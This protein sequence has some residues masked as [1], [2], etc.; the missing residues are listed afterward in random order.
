M[1]NMVQHGKIFVPESKRAELMKS[2]SSTPAYSGA[3]NNRALRG[4]SVNAREDAYL[5][6]VDTLTERSRDLCRNNSLARGIIE[7]SKVSTIGEGLQPQ[8]RIDAEYL[9]LSEEKTA[10]LQKQIEREFRFFAETNECDAGRRHTFYGLQPLIFSTVMRDGNALALLPFIPRGQTYNL[11]IQTILGTRLQNPNSTMDTDKLKG[12]V[13]LGY[14]GDPVAYHISSTN[15]FG[16]TTSTKRVPAFGKESGR[17]NVLHIYLADDPN[18]IKGV[19]LLSSVIETVKQVGRISA[20]EAQ[21]LVVQSQWAV[22]IENPDLELDPNPDRRKTDI[23]IDVGGV[24]ELAAGE[25]INMA[26]PTRPN[27]SFEPF[28]MALF[29][30]IGMAMQIP[31]EILINHFQASYSASRGA[32]IEHWKKIMMDRS[33]F[34]DQFCQPVYNEVLR[35]GVLRGR[36]N[37]PGFLEDPAIRASYCRAEWIGTNMGQLDPLKEVRAAVEAIQGMLSTHQGE[38][39]RLNG[40]DFDS[41][42]SQ[43]KRETTALSGV[44]FGNDTVP[45]AALPPD[46]AANQAITPENFYVAL[47]NIVRGI[48]EEFQN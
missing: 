17:R 41:N 36:L 26:T 23:D 6:D 2:Q 42:V 15:T 37:L 43:L 18:Q 8:S 1:R 48:M 21:A 11:C 3:G 34:I 7:K 33:W 27:T 47:E 10:E 13:E 45:P 24:Y 30:Q 28:L 9:G 5:D 4:W 19:P 44:Q 25:K 46:A 14:Y 35:E 20:A 31:F 40:G 29:K 12:G 39:A 38:T 32:K 16:M 22:F